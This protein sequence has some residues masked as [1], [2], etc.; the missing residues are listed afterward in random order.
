MVEIIGKSETFSY[1]C[2]TLN[3][4][5]TRMARANK[6]NLPIISDIECSF[7]ENMKDVKQIETVSIGHIVERIQSD[8][9]KK[10]IRKVRRLRRKDIL[11]DDRHTVTGSLQYTLS[12]P[13]KE[14]LPSIIPSGIFSKRS[15]GGLLEYKNLMAVDYDHIPEKEVESLRITLMENPHVYTVFVSPSG[16]GLKVIVPV[17]GTE[18]THRDT[19]L[20]WG[21]DFP[22]KYWDK[23]VHDYSRLMFLSWDPMIT[24]NDSP[25]PYSYTPPEKEKPKRILRPVVRSKSFDNRDMQSILETVIPQLPSD[26]AD[27]RISWIAGLNAIISEFGEGGR[28]LAHLFSKLSS[29]YSYEETDKKFD[30][31]SVTNTPGGATVATFAYWASQHK[32]PF[33]SSDELLFTRDKKSIK[34]VAHELDITEDEAKSIKEG[35]KEKVKTPVIALEFINDNYDFRTNVVNGMIESFST[36]ETVD[37]AKMYTDLLKG[38]YD[39]SPGQVKT[40]CRSSEIAP[41]FNPIKD[42]FEGLKEVKVDEFKEI[43]RLGDAVILNDES[44]REWFRTMLRKMMVRSVAC[45]MGFAPNRTVFMLTDNNA[46]MIGKSTWIRY[47]GGFDASKRKVHKLSKY[48]LEESLRNDKDMS[49]AICENFIWNVEEYESLSPRD[50]ARFKMTVSKANSK[51]RRSYATHPE[52]MDRRCNFW[53]ST[54]QSEMLNDV[55]NTRYIIFHVTDVLRNYQDGDNKVDMD[56]V[57]AEAYHKFLENPNWGD[58]TREDAMEQGVLNEYH[59]ISDPLED[60]IMNMTHDDGDW[61]DVPCAVF[62]SA[63]RNKGVMRSSQQLT[64]VMSPLHEF[65]KKRRTPKMRYYSIKSTIGRIGHLYN[66][67]NMTDQNPFLTDDDTGSAIM[68]PQSMS[69][70]QNSRP[71]F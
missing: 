61:F 68:N 20:Q 7:W 65:I 62:N 17:K 47:I 9:L 5:R 51:E 15:K 33:N 38:G 42:Y 64:K 60:Y 13:E 4:K 34:E 3:I 53:A 69:Q 45:G 8:D 52:I 10:I 28:G 54:N 40:I 63:A 2:L 48:Y 44:Q 39:L 59:Q 71:N 11:N 30:S 67:A 19:Y 25:K 46:Q 31:E 21:K 50:L 14:K 57:W 56:D 43:D 18:K 49:I 41:K 27:G 55:N 70:T 16:E 58:L 24:T 32:I 23:N 37:D 1:F 36:G 29:K 66:D 6:Q 12:K 35:V 22:N 26:Y